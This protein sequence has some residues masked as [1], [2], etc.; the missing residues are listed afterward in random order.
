MKIKPHGTWKIEC[1]FFTLAQIVSVGI[2]CCWRYWWWRDDNAHADDD[3]DDGNAVGADA[4]PAA[5]ADDTDV[6]IFSYAMH[7]LPS[8]VA[9]CSL[10]ICVQNKRDKHQNEKLLF[11]FFL[12][13]S[14]LFFLSVSVGDQQW[15]SSSSSSSHLCI[16]FYKNAVY[17]G[18]SLQEPHVCAHKMSALKRKGRPGA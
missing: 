6:P 15:S 8:F 14:G 7:S 18:E 16:L 9:A 1:T 17:E 2:V 4:A 11:Y 12:F 10:S 5:P 3:D 13:F